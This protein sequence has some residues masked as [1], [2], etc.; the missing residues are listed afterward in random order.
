MAVRDLSGKM[1]GTDLVGKL[2][3]DMVLAAMEGLA[4]VLVERKAV[5]LFLVENQEVDSVHYLKWTCSQ[6]DR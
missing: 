2:V 1:R 4:S 5:G 6:N 3:A